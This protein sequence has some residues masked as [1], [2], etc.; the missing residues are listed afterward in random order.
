M[1]A[2]QT[3]TPQDGRCRFRG[4]YNTPCATQPAS[5]WSLEG[6]TRGRRLCS[7]RPSNLKVPKRLREAPDLYMIRLRFAGGDPRREQRREKKKQVLQAE[8]DSP[9]PP[10]FMAT[11]AAFPLMGRGIKPLLG[12]TTASC[13]EGALRRARR[14]LKDLREK[15]PHHAVHNLP[16]RR[17][18]TEH[19]GP[20]GSRGFAK[21]RD[22]R[23]RR[24]RLLS[25]K[26]VIGRHAT[27]RLVLPKTATERAGSSPAGSCR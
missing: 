7:A 3:D 14:P 26:T 20:F 21:R 12:T 23:W 27:P 19:L 17:P 9:P 4:R 2:G 13:L 15:K 8:L 1:S 25:G 6:G 24:E 18:Q 5:V 16:G 22:L 11:Q 10:G